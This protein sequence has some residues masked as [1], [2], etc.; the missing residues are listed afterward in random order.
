MKRKEAVAAT[1]KGADKQSRKTDLAGLEQEFKT[2]RE[3]ETALRDSENIWR[4]DCRRLHQGESL[5]QISVKLYELE[6]QLIAQREAPSPDDQQMTLIEGKEYPAGLAQRFIFQT[7]LEL[8]NN[9]AAILL[10]PEY[11]QRV[12][13][14]EIELDELRQ[15]IEE[16]EEAETLPDK[17]KKEIDRR[18]AE[19]EK[20]IDNDMLKNAEA[21]SLE[22]L[23][24][25]REVIEAFL[26]PEIEKAMPF[27]GAYETIKINWE[28]KGAEAWQKQVEKILNYK[29]EETAVEMRN[30]KKAWEE[31]EFK[32]FPY[33]VGIRP[34]QPSDKEMKK[35]SVR[36]E[37]REKM[38]WFD[39]RIEEYA[40][41]E[42]LA[43]AILQ[44]IGTAIEASLA[45]D[46]EGRNLSGFFVSNLEVGQDWQKVREIM[47]FQYDIEESFRL[48]IGEQINTQTVS[49]GIEQDVYDF[50]YRNFIDML[51]GV[52]GPYG[53]VKNMV[54]LYK[55]FGKSAWNFIS[56]I[57]E[58]VGKEFFLSP[59]RGS[60]RLATGKLGE[61]DKRAKG[62]EKREKIIKTIKKGIN[63]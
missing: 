14:R 27:N 3:R 43:L 28:G 4:E 40:K 15:E 12:E 44:R 58:A 42:K 32:K 10:S 41:S 23:I 21:L 8:V 11:L 46:P 31:A 29:L 22:G 9:A 38:A 57:P 13:D 59:I 7:R 33:Q 39:L 62:F 25:I 37:H 48:E 45:E 36:N 24:K 47:Q 20:A 50:A 6:K 30:V 5:E 56:G 35:P 18:I 51:R 1:M 61:W 2:R 52:F 54:G 60:F 26:D 49:N 34:K 19:I 63:T 53:S 55:A 16:G 17:R